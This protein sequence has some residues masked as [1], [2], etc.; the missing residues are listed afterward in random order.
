MNRNILQVAI[1]YQVSIE[2]MQWLNKSFTSGEFP[3]CLKQAN[4]SPIFKKDDPL[5]KE[6]CRPVSILPLL[7]KVYEKFFIIDCLIM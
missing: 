5:D 2:Q 6:N 1:Q 3:D 7:S 4:I